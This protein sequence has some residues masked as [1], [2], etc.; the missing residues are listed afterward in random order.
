MFLIVI[1]KVFF[2][3]NIHSF[4]YKYMLYVIIF[5]SI[6]SMLNNIRTGYLWLRLNSTMFVP[7][8]CFNFL[9]SFV[10]SSFFANKWCA[11]CP[12]AFFVCK[13]FYSFF[14]RRYSKTFYCL[15]SPIKKK[16]SMNL[17]FVFFFYKCRNSAT[18]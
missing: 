9:S 13:N 1:I 14:L 12:S 15:L 4:I 2:F 11:F 10:S 16:K 18:L 5:I 3:I 7:C 17:T 8:E 6:D